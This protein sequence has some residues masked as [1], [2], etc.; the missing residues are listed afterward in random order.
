MT[1]DSQLSVDDQKLVVIIAGEPSGDL[2]A[3]QVA[4]RLKEKLPEIELI[5]MGGD[6]ME[7]AGVKLLFHIR[8]SA[9]MGI[10]EVL[11]TIPAFLQ[12]QRDQQ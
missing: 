6:L 11:N 8:D 5:G 9:V 2:H 12:K 1:T 3:S 4:Q 7:S 10:S